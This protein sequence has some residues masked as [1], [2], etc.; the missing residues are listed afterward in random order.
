MYQLDDAAVTGSDS[1]RVSSRPSLLLLWLLVAI[2]VRSGRW[3]L[4]CHSRLTMGEGRLGLLVLSLSLVF[5]VDCRGGG[6]RSIGTEGFSS[7]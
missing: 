5:Y 6:L 4:G 7:V 1:G 2:Y 3:V